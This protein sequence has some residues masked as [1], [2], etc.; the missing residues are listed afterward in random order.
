MKRLVATRDIKVNIHGV[1][2][3]CLL[4]PKDKLVDV[5]YRQAPEEHPLVKEM[6][7]KIRKGAIE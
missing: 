5:D 3:D 4:I 6:I 7:D 1:E 2:Y